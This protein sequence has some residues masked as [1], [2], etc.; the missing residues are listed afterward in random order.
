MW[1]MNVC[2]SID[3]GEKNKPNSTVE[4]LCSSL[5]VFSM[6]SAITHFSTCKKNTSV[7]CSDS[8]KVTRHTSGRTGRRLRCPECLFG[9]LCSKQPYKIFFSR[10][11]WISSHFFKCLVLKL[12]SGLWDSIRFLFYVHLFYACCWQKEE[13][14]W[15]KLRYFTVHLETGFEDLGRNSGPTEI[16]SKTSVGQNF[17][18]GN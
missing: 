8:M 17:T 15:P 4:F 11:Y 18:P 12:C 5:S 3:G 14:G 2:F 7:N 6:K 9:H 13:E 16:N 10:I 1:T